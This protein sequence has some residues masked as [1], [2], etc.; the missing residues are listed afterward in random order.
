MKK[1]FKRILA[2]IL[3]PKGQVPFYKIKDT[4]AYNELLLEGYSDKKINVSKNAIKKVLEKQ[5]KHIN[6][7]KQ[8]G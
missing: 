5:K 6:R 4:N 7:N 3:V 2:V 1:F 8:N